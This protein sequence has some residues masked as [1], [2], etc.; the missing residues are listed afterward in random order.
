M[1]TVL[2]VVHNHPNVMPGGAETYA[3]ELYQVMKM[4][5][6]Y[7]P[8]LVARTGPPVSRGGRAHEGTLLESVGADPDEFYFH[9]EVEANDWFLSSSRDKAVY[10]RYFRDLLLAYRPDV[11]HFQHTLFLGYDIL[12][13]TRRTLP[14]AKIVY[15]LHEYVPICHN[16]GQMM[17]TSGEL[18]SRATPRRC[19]ECFP[20]ISPQQFFLREEVH[21]VASGGGGPVRFAEPVLDRPLRG[22]G[23]F[24]REDCP[25]AKWADAGTPG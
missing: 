17:T 15:T 23:H 13:E 12:R 6:R 2:Y 3:T 19:H 25:G 16:S 8:V 9:T 22:L 4:S 1:R 18:C 10:T 14:S 20:D 5:S 7:K 24:S 11:V 21:Q